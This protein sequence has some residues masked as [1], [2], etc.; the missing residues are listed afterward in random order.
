MREQVTGGHGPSDPAPVG[1]GGRARALILRPLDLSVVIPAHN[2]ADTLAE[3]LDALLAQ[4]WDGEWEVVV[5]DNRST[6][7]T[8]ALVAEYAARDPRIRMVTAPARAGRSYA[9]DVGLASATADAIAFCDGDDIVGPRWVAAMG[10]GLRE[11]RVVTGPLDS[12]RLNPD[13]LAESR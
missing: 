7:G 8:A 9:R 3:Q 1:A 10:D 4:Q 11:H 12:S 13:W 2:V 5:V 6:D